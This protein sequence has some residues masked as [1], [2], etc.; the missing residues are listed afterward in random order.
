MNRPNR[1]SRT[2]SSCRANPMPQTMPPM[3]WLRAVLG[4]M[5][6]PPAI[7]VTTRVTRTV[8]KSSSTSTSAKIAE[9]VCRE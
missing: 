4:L 1:W 7:A 8:P 9:C 5:I 2:L 6:R 3:T